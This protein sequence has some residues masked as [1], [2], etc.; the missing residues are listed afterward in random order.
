MDISRLK[1]EELIPPRLTI[2]PVP[3]IG[4]EPFAEALRDEVGEQIVD[5][6][7]GYALHRLGPDPRDVALLYDGEFV[8]LVQNAVAHIRADHQGKGLAAPLILQSCQHWEEIPELQ[9]SEAGAA[10]LQAAWKVAT[11]LK[12]CE[13]G[14]PPYPP[15]ARS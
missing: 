4:F 5:L 2:H 14:L 6:G 1:L 11:G 15:L 7:K 13:W 8:G 12:Q 10:A 3:T 9:L